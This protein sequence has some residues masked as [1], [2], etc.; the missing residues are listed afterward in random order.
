MR[1]IVVFIIKKEKV[2]VMFRRSVKVVVLK[3]VKIRGIVVC[4]VCKFKS[5]AI[6]QHP[7]V[8]NVKLNAPALIKS[9]KFFLIKSKKALQ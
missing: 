3:E 2:D 1:K 7:G 4:E 6:Y 8:L 9:K 5:E